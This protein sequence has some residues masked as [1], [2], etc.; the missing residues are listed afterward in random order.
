MDGDWNAS[1][2]G[3]LAE[4]SVGGE[5]AAWGISRL[6]R[7]VLERAAHLAV[8][9]SKL[10]VYCYSKSGFTCIHPIYNKTTD[11]RGT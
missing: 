3:H 6:Q 11:E 1:C 2:V 4:K 10:V 9:A 7:L 5:T 8:S